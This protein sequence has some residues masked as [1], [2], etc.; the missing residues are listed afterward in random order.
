MSSTPIEPLVISGIRE[1]TDEPRPALRGRAWRVAPVAI[2]AGALAIVAASLETSADISPGRILCA[3]VVTLWSVCALFVARRRSHELLPLLMA[4]GALAGAL[5]LVG[6][7]VLGRDISASDAD[8]AAAVR[9]FGI[10]L[11]PAIGAHLAFGMP[12]G[13]LRTTGRRVIVVML[14]VAA[15]SVGALA[16]SDRPDLDFAPL[17]GLASVAVLTSAIAFI[18]RGQRAPMA[19]RSRFQWPAWG[20]TVAAAVG[21]GAVVLNALV[22]WPESLEAIAVGATALVPFSIAIAAARDVPVRI[23]RLL[24]HTITLAGL[25]G[26]VGVSYLV[27]VLGLGRDPNEDE[28]SLLGLSMLA[29]ALAALLWVPTRERLDDFA[30]RR[31]YG[32]RHAPDEVLR[33]FGSRLTRALPLDELLLQLAESL[34][35]T[36]ALER[37]EVWTQAA[38]GKLERAVSVPDRGPA[39]LALGAEEETVVARAGVSGPAWARVWLPSLVAG[40]SEEAV[41]RVAPITNSG[42]LL[43]LMVVRRPDGAPPFGEDDDQALTELARQVGLALHNVT[44]DSALQESLDEVR[45]QADEIRASRA[46]IVQAGDAQRRAIERDLH[47]GAQQHLVAL[48]VSVRLARTVADSDPEQAKVM[49]EQIGID[50]Q[51]AVQELRRLAHGIYPPL[52]AERG[53]GEALS[54][55]A[56]RAALPTEIRA[57]GIGRFA[58]PIEAALYFCVLEAL[59]NAGKHAGDGAEATVTVREDEGAL[60]FEVADDGAGFDLSS[61]AQQGHGFVNMN[62]RVGA[63]GGTVT[64]D[65]APSKGTRIS[66]RIPITG[67]TVRTSDRPRFRG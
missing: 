16:F 23:D 65:S 50:L 52:L 60:L 21:L 34:K 66:G 14:Y 28:R 11:L 61:G 30:T 48:A 15:L 55:A 27:V 37:A 44:L 32:E 35:A 13:A 49:M 25:F 9:A 40:G 45:R 18:A 12:D 58:Q 20:V 54:A 42:E 19:E 67:T 26:L 3:V 33:T 4:L 51:D 62:D 38:S 43:G 46:R 8:L 53:L 31:V 17:V 1:Y 64:V 6:A 22:D 10:A 47:D 36:M 56:G 29:A 41:M 7:V 63:I 2:A 5:A 59:Q 57:D 24:V 39:E